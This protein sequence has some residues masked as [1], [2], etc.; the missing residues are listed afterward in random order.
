MSQIQSMRA[1]RCNG[2]GPQGQVHWTSINAA[3]MQFCHISQAK[4]KCF[5]RFVFV[6]H[7][8]Q[9]K[10]SVVFLAKFAYLF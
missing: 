7:I 5:Q 6:I 8:F 10:R 4:S 1:E 3:Q 9:E 2:Q